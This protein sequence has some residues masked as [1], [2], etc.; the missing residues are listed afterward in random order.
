MIIHNCNIRRSDHSKGKLA[1]LMNLATTNPNK[2][3][4][5]IKNLITVSANLSYSARLLRLGHISLAHA[6]RNH[7]I[8][9]SRTK[10]E[11][12]RLDFLYRVA[13]AHR[14]RITK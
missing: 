11:F 2:F 7:T 1:Y 10:Q 12:R 9:T 5:E 14:D 8:T 13:T 4:Q 6:R 3:Q